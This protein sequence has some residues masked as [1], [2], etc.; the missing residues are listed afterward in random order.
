MNILFAAGGTGGH[1][2]PAVAVAHEMTRLQPETGILFLTGRRKL[3]E[4]IIRNA[5]FECRTLP[6]VGL[7]R[8]L[9]A[10]MLPFAWNL[11]VSILKARGT[12][13]DFAPSVVFSTGGYV[14]G[15]TVMAARMSGVPVV[16]QEQNSF[17]GMANRRLGKKADLILLGMEGARKYFTAAGET[18]VTGNP[19]RPGI[20]GA[21][22]VAAASTFGLDPGK[23]TVLVFGGS[24]GARAI[25][26]VFAV[27][28]HRLADRGVQVIWQ[29]GSGEYPE[30]RSLDGGPG[31]L[32]RVLEF[33]DTM[34][35]AYAASDLVVSRAGA[36]TI[37]EITACGLPS[38]LVPLPTAAANHQEW[39]A[40]E[41]EKA[42][43]AVVV[44]EDELNPERCEQAILGI[45]GSESELTSRSAASA[46]LGRIDAAERIAELI[47]GRY[48]DN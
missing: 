16:I 20:I 10:R 21:G 8:R 46:S 47:I 14:S 19:V 32:V 45:L 25:N 18:V 35:E 2:Y 4:Q 37:A 41:L 6:V 15:P 5:G 7:P 22:R 13:T 17:P 24:Q 12:V 31:G 40:R 38:V 44:T 23:K 34:G 27:T 3:E 9:S 48:G 28:A 1:I 43:A 36:M 39:N 29:T 30:Y 42:G 33:I 11:G 26:M